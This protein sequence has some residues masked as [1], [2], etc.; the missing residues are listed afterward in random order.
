MSERKSEQEIWK[1]LK[2]D[3]TEKLEELSKSSDLSDQVWKAALEAYL[4][5]PEGDWNILVQIQ[6]SNPT[7]FA[8]LFLLGRVY[9]QIGRPRR[10][11]AF[12][13]KAADLDVGYTDINWE[14]EIFN[15]YEWLEMVYLPK[16]QGFEDPGDAKAAEIYATAL[17]SIDKGQTDVAKNKLNKALKLD[18]EAAAIWTDLGHIENNLGNF[19]A[20]LEAYEKAKAVQ[21]EKAVCWYNTGTVYFKLNKFEIAL[22]ELKKSLELDPDDPDTIYNTGLCYWN[23]DQFAEAKTFFEDCLFLVPDYLNALFYM[24]KLQ[25]REK[26]IEAAREKVRQMLELQPNWK[27]YFSKDADLAP[28]I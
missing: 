9:D 16:I 14:I 1:A 20:S 19:D 22:S 2:E 24:A 15:R 21:A 25:A 8:P 10:A 11:Y 13:C 28:L 26:E 4:A 6:K 5:F 23:L 3:N 12:L 17:D 7:H 27:N 18:S